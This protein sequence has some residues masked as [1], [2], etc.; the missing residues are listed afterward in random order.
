MMLHASSPN[1][2]SAIAETLESAGFEAIVGKQRVGNIRAEKVTVKRVK[3][4]DRARVL[5]IARTVDPK[6]R[7]LNL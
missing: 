1:R 6:V 2:A 3:T 7:L 5:E 4:E